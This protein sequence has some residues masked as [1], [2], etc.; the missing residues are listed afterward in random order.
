MCCTPSRS[1]VT[2]CGSSLSHRK[3]T[4][5]VLLAARYVHVAPAIETALQG[6][7]NLDGRRPVAD[8]WAHQR[9]RRNQVVLP[10]RPY[11]G[12]PVARSFRLR[13][14]RRC[15]FGA[16][17]VVTLTWTAT[18]ATSLFPANHGGANLSRDIPVRPV[19]A[20]GCASSTSSRDALGT[21]GWLGCG[22]RGLRAVG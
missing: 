3:V 5:K 11:A 13:C 18:N 2:K 1:K 20:R 14:L 15:R 17:F 4:K 21:L 19:S 10:R 8:W 22:R 12:K 9:D 6:R 16:A 7:A